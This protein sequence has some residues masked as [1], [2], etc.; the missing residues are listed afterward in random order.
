MNILIWPGMLTTVL[1]TRRD[2]KPEEAAA[3]MRYVRKITM[4]ALKK[5]LE[6]S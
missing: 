5:P 3:T 1:N 2:Y 4:N 6:L